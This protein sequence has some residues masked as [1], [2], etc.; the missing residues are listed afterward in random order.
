M[1]QDGQDGQE[2]QTVWHGLSVDSVDTHASHES[3]VGKGSIRAS[4]NRS[5][6]FCNS[7]LFLEASQE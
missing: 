6:V 1:G 4:K 3:K 7:D 2:D 5:T